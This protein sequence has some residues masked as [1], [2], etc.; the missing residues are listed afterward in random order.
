MQLEGGLKDWAV[1][2]IEELERHAGAN[3]GQLAILGRVPHD[4]PYL[5]GESYLSIPF[6]FVPSAVWGAKPEAGGKLNAIRIYDQPLTA[7]PPGAVGEAYWNFS[8]PGIVLVFLVYGVFL[9]WVAC[10]YHANAGH[11]LIMVIFV[12]SLFY[13]QPTTPSIY[14]FF[15]Q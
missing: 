12:Y 13:L 2:A 8:Y 10:A 11:S 9:K 15:M 6:V 5:Y 4:V 14:G 3:N 7:I 1:R